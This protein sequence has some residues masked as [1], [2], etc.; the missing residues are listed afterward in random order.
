MKVTDYKLINFTNLMVPDISL[1]RNMRVHRRTR[2]LQVIQSLGTFACPHHQLAL[3]PQE[4]PE[5]T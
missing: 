3:Q 1:R 5:T 2:I 4:A